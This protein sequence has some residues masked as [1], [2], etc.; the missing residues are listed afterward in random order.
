MLFRAVR[1][2]VCYH[3]RK[4][5][6]NKYDNDAAAIEAASLEKFLAKVLTTQSFAPSRNSLTAA[7]ATYFYNLSDSFLLLLFCN[8]DCRGR[9]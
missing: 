1:W 7:E 9:T 4:K 8:A 6:K 5:S 2:V 3:R